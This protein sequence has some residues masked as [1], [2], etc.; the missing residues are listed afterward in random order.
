M[1][2]NN[3]NLIENSL[4]NLNLDLIDNKNI[5]KNVELDTLKLD[6]Y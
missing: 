3:L 4:N 2:E 1:D 5:Y 6:K